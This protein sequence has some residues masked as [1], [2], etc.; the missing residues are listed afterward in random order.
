MTFP[1][2]NCFV[3]MSFKECR[4]FTSLKQCLSSTQ[5]ERVDHQTQFIDQ[6]Q[7]HQ[8]GYKGFA[9]DNHHVPTRL[10]LHPSDLL[11]I[12]DNPCHFPCDLVKGLGNDYMGYFI[13]TTCIG[14]LI[15]SP[16]RVGRE[17]ANT[18]HSQDTSLVP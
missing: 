15:L 3:S 10:L 14:V 18:V 16:C 5:N 7:I 13:G 11:H 9:A 6:A 4:S 1:D 2:F 17:Q 12:S 8:T